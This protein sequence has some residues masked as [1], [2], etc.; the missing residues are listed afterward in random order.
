MGK[1]IID[2]RNINFSFTKNPIFL[3]FSCS[4]IEN[5]II[6]I[7]GNSGCGKSTLLNLI[8]GLLVP[9]SGNISVNGTLVYLTQY[10]TL[11]PYHNAYENALLACDLRNTKTAQKEKEASALFELFKLSEDSKYKF[12]QELSGGMQQRVGLIQTLLI[13][14][15]LYLLDE[16]LKEIDRATG[17]IIQGYIWNK[18]KENNISAII[19][20]HDIEQSV[21]VSDKI[22]FLSTNKPVEEYVFNKDFRHL[23]PDKRLKSK[24][25]EEHILHTIKKLS[26]L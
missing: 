2:T 25:Y 20:T 22:L 21:L 7:I 8:S 12:P 26:E 17:L 10:L 18:F 24:Y 4:F 3:D 16:P 5:E 9:A 14:A 11:L 19:V 13:D 23:P 15:N 6:T 1:N